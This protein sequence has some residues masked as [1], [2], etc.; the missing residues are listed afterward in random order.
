MNWCSRWYG[1]FCAAF[2]SIQL[3]LESARLRV[4]AVSSVMPA[5]AVA[6][7]WSNPAKT[8]GCVTVVIENDL[9]KIARSGRLAKVETTLVLLDQAETM[10][11]R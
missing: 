5:N 6:R 3:V 1:K 2:S 7:S 11:S 8:G 9:T 10:M 4:S